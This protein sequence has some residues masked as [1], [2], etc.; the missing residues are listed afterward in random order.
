MI[1]LNFEAF[2]HFEECHHLVDTTGNA[3]VGFI[4]G[5]KPVFYL[6]FL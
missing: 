2:H 6:M 3:K 5:H 4:L 1:D